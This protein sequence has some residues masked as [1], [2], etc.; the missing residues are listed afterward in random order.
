MRTKIQSPLRV[1]LLLLH[2]THLQFAAFPE[3]RDPKD[4]RC[5]MILFK[6]ARSDVKILQNPPSRIGQI[7]QKSA[8]NWDDFR[9]FFTQ[10]S[11]CGFFSADFVL[12]QKWPRGNIYLFLK[13]LFRIFL[14][15]LIILNTITI[16]QLI[17]LLDEKLR[18]KLFF[19][20]R[21]SKTA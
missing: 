15:F 6:S 19:D 7:R 8:R 9:P 10:G 4:Q 13:I 17:F 2:S 20:N 5:Q 14:F 12:S 3:F 1:M 11:F 21:D 18:N 16:Y